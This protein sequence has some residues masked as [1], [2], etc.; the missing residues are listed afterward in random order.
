MSSTPWTL[1][2]VIL[3]DVGAGSTA[4]T[5][6]SPTLA[7][8][9]FDSSDGLVVH[10]NL[11][12]PDP[13]VL[14]GVTASDGA[15]AATWAAPADGGAEVLAYQVQATSTAEVV[16][17]TSTDLSE[18]LGATVGPLTNDLPYT[19]VVRA[20]NTIG[21]SA[22]SNALS[23]TPHAGLPPVAPIPSVPQ[24]PPLVVVPA[25]PL[26]AFPVDHLFRPGNFGLTPAEAAAAEEAEMMARAARRGATGG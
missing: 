6:V 2:L 19:V 24:P 16:T 12:V 14:T 11:T 18:P 25:P 8:P 13:P 3:T 4:I 5:T 10:P 15:V 17:V 1:T 23:T 9:G 20:I 22:D 26:Y 7:A 21:G